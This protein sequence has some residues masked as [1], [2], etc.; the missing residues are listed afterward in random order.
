[1]DLAVAGCHVVH[2]NVALLYKEISVVNKQGGTVGGPAISPDLVPGVFCVEPAYLT[3]RN[4]CDTHPACRRPV[5]GKGACHPADLGFSVF[6]IINLYLA[7]IAIVDFNEGQTFTIGRPAITLNRHPVMY[8]AYQTPGF[9]LTITK[10]AYPE[11]SI[12]QVGKKMLIR[13]EG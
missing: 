6:V 8:R 7:Y 10:A 13:R 4:R 11:L 12:D 9:R 2:K 3:I 5:T 1:M